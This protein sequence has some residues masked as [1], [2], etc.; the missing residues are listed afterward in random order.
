LISIVPGKGTFVAESLQPD[1]ED[2]S[3]GE[4]ED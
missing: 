3:Q 2:Q 1:A 4:T